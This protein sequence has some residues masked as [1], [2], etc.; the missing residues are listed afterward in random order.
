MCGSLKP[1]RSLSL[2]AAQRCE[3][4]TKP[5][6]RCRCGGA[7]HGA[8]RNGDKKLDG[9]FFA[10]LPA[11]DPHHLKPKKKRKP[12]QKLVQMMMFEGS[13]ENV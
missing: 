2:R 4:A 12:K 11:D 8:K 6:C 10:T 3:A 7:Y 9:E 5:T 1:L 13:V